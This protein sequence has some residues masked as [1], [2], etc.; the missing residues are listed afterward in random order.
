MAVGEVGCDRDPL[1]ALAT[2][3]LGGSLELL[4]GETVEQHRILQ[5]AATVFV[6]QIAGDDAASRLIG[7]DADK[8]RPLVRCLDGA[9]GEKTADGVRLLVE[10]L[11]QAIPDLLL[12]RMIVGDGEGHEP[13]RIY[14]RPEP[15]EQ[16][17]VDA[18]LVALFRRV[19]ARPLRPEAVGV[20]VC[21]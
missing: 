13:R 20:G 11:R 8:L 21:R 4:G 10:A 9:F 14:L 5:P 1:P 7:F 15:I 17:R 3:V 12:P 19:P 2:Q 18:M 6:K 16:I